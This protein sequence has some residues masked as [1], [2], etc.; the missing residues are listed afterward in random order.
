ML[1]V[2]IHGVD[3]VIARH[4]AGKQFV[5]V[6]E[7]DGDAIEGFSGPRGREKFANRGSDGSRGTDLNGIRNVVIVTAM[8]V[9]PRILSS[10][11]G[12]RHVLVLLPAICS[13]LRSG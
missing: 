3:A 2:V 1:E 7:C 4:P 12:E 9:H 10:W 11:E 5:E 13:R 6:I 8:I